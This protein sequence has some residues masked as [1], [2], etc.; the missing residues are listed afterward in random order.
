MI[1]GEIDWRR[2]MKIQLEWQDYLKANHLHIIQT[3]STTSFL[4]TNVL[5][6]LNGLGLWVVYFITEESLLLY[7]FLFLIIVSLFN[8]LFNFVWMPY[9]AKKV[10]EQQKNMQ[11]NIE[12]EVLEFGLRETSKIGEVVVPWSDFH[13]WREDED[14]LMLYLSKVMFTIIPKSGVKDNE[15]IEGIMLKLKENG[16]EQNK[17]NK[18]DMKKQYTISA[19]VMGG[20]LVINILVV[21][22][23]LALELFW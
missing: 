3:S 9:Q 17:G 8:L 18:K 4:I 19:S 12:I 21:V 5:M 14:Y 7:L 1:G 10:F 2:S 6:L 16:V 15:E 11:R 20:L 23:L 13:E 22:F